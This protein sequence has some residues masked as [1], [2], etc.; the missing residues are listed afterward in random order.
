MSGEKKEKKY[1]YIKKPYA[2]SGFYCFF[3]SVLSLFLFIAAMGLSLH[4]GGNSGMNAGA[5]GFSSMIMALFGLWF[6]RLSFHEQGCNYLFA[7][8]GGA[9]SGVL[10]LIWIGILIVGFRI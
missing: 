10:L 7:R 5:L 4:A 8:I 6:L 1:S 2:R 3:L 9:L